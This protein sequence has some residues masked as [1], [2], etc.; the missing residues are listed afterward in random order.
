MGDEIKLI[1]LYG[2][3]G[4][5]SGVKNQNLIDEKLTCGYRE[6]AKKFGVIVYMSP[7]KRLKYDWEKVIYNEQEIINF[8]N[9][10]PKAIVWS[11]KYNKSKNNVLK[12]INNF[13]I[14]YSCNAENTLNKLCNISLVDTPKRVIYKSHRLHIKGKD[15]E[16]WK[17]TNEPRR[18][19]YVLMGK[20]DDKNQSYFIKA[21]N[22]VKESRRI[23]WIGGY[24]FYTKIK[25][26]HEI[27]WIPPCSPK[28][29]VDWISLAKVGILYSE[30][31]AEG[32]PQSFLEMTMCGV[33]VVYGGP[34]NENYFFEH[35]HLRPK[36]KNL[37]AAAEQ[38]LKTYNSALCRE[39]A[40]AHYSIEKSFE[41]MKNM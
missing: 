14:H 5:T 33:P 26:P 2:G 4:T 29:V 39:E 24:A 15:P 22:E 38:L 34:Y 23:L 30:I 17:P 6:Y 16:F 27:T 40:I 36:K 25:S 32:F 20:R 18:Y 11:V 37:V 12:G 41:N 7:Q 19:D 3:I 28:K 13:K 1:I 31:K 10:Y 8:C 35:N 21:M 9:K